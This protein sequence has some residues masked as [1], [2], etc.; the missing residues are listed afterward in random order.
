GEWFSN[1]G[2]NIVKGVWDG[3]TGMADWFGDKIGDFFGG[4]VDGV[5][6]FLGIKSPSKVFAGIGQ[7]M[8]LGLGQG[9][10]QEIIGI[11]QDIQNAIP[12]S[13]N[14][15]FNVSGSSKNAQGNLNPSIVLNQTISSPKALSVYEV[16]RQTKNASQVLAVALMKG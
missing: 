10:S 9:F 14:S 3:I 15:S 2:E 7:N 1:I 11:N 5:K 16:Y 13:M 12:T 6:N 8:A 4:M